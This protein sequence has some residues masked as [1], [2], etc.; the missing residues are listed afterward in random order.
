MITAQ[1]IR[2][3]TFEKSKNGYDMACIDDYLEEIA[4]EISNLQKENNSMKGKM[5]VLVAKIEEYRGNEDAINKTLL[6]AQKLAAQIESDARERAAAMIA[7]AQKTV[8]E[9]IGTIKEQAEAQEARL[10]SAEAATKKFIDGI[11]AMCNAQMKNLDNI[12]AGLNVPAAKAE[13]A[14]AVEEDDDVKV[15][16]PAN[17]DATR[18]FSF[19]L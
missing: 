4:D 2:E 6:S 9:Q 1:D 8:D 16:A 13:A 19:E 10:A 7:E 18:A 5:K 11:R 17:A 15:A 14:P 12:E 3:K